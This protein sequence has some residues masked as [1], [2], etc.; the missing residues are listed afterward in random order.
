MTLTVGVAMAVVL[1]LGIVS[2]TAAWAYC[3]GHA[4]GLRRAR[5][6]AYS[7]S[8]HPGRLAPTPPEKSAWV[9][10]GDTIVAALDKET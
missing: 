4:H 1:G 3:L 2:V 5:A 9:R 6:V 10:C 8:G 7:V